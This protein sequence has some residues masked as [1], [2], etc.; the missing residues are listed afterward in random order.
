MPQKLIHPLLMLIAG[1]TEKDMV[2]YIEYLK[3]ENQPE[4]AAYPPPRAS[5]NTNRKKKSELCAK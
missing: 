3:A 2:L 4:P 1:A 5:I